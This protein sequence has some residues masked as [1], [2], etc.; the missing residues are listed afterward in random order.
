MDSLSAGVEMAERLNVM[1]LAI[2]ERKPATKFEDD[3][4]PTG[5]TFKGPLMVAVGTV[6]EKRVAR[7]TGDTFFI[8]SPER[9]MGQ[10]RPLAGIARM[11]F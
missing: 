2:S 3:N 6:D 9:G 7:P 4:D 5:K 10:D 8:V 1:S 11:P